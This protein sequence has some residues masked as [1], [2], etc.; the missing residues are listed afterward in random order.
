MRADRLLSILLLLQTH[1]RMTASSLARR[2]E[3]SPRTIHRD[4]EALSMAGVPVYAERG[5]GGGWVL[6]ESFR[7]Q[8]TGLTESE[9]RALFVT[10][11]AK[12]LADL[13]LEKASDAALVKVLAALP[14]VARGNAEHM[15]QRIHVD[16]AGWRQAAEE[17]PALPLLQE[18]VWIERRLRLLYR[19]NDGETRERIVD[20][21]GLVAKGR[22]WYLVAAVDGDLRT[23]R[24]SRVKEVTIVDEPFTRPPD[25]DL[26][27]YW[28]Q[29]SAE[30]VANLPRYPIVVRIAPEV[31]RRLWIP[32]AYA[33]IDRVGEPEGDGWHTASLILQTEHE[34][35]S[36]VLGFGPKMEVI[37]P[38]ELRERVVREARAI[39]SFYESRTLSSCE[40]RMT[41]GAL[42]PFER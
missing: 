1:Q 7:T 28:A 26:A 25:F 29:S 39:V 42:C 12:V 30:L 8:V 23:F 4:M 35:C 37:E 5:A 34:A 15:R 21:L 11:P 3:V 33:R 9:I 22:L 31:V 20:P 38:P 27:A 16:G 41:P 14:S 32:G 18:A 6:P 24:V 13:G 10:L 36:Y 2:L 40:S 19:R 17:V